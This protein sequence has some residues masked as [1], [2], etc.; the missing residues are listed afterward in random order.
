MSQAIAPARTLPRIPVLNV[1]L[2]LATVA[3]TLLAGAG[4]TGLRDPPNV[5]SL[6]L[7]GLPFATA[8]IG[9][10]LCHEM[11]HYLMARAYDVDASLPFFIPMPMGQVGTFGAVIRIR[12]AIPTRTAV[13]DIGSAGPFAG[14]VVALPL[15]AWGIAH[16]EVRP[17]GDAWAASPVGMSAWRWLEARLLTGAWPDASGGQFFGDSLVTWGMQRLILGKLAP[18]YDVF[19]HPVAFAAWF[20]LFVTT[21]NLFPI[22]Q[23]DG[24]HVTYALL[25][26]GRARALSRLVSWALFACG[27]LVSWTW[28]PWWAVT[29]FAVRFGHPPA[30][31]EEPLSPGRRAL[32][33]LALVVFAATFIPV[34]FS[35]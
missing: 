27:V 9:I 6:V 22:G 31:V 13:F 1:A 5:T 3:T 20:G 16:S 2:F 26:Q 30:L 28:L 33:V 29:R 4:Q 14:F 15:L 35:V 19:L 32:A 17:I 18:G 25:G 34:P 24:G 23:L 10:L 8:L 21:L 7:A 12:S 11:G